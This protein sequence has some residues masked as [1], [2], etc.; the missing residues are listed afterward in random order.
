MFCIILG[1]KLSNHI[2]NS[3]PHLRKRPLTN[4]SLKQP[5]KMEITPMTKVADLKVYAKEK[6]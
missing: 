6:G 5:K 1:L 3:S 2:N 4:F